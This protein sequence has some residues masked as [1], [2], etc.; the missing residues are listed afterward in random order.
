MVNGLNTFFNEY[1]N[2]ELLNK[3]FY[4]PYYT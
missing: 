1:F 2:P 3:W 4:K